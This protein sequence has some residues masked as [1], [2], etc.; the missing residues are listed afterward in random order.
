MTT[1]PPFDP[2]APLA[3]PPD[4]WESAPDAEPAVR[5][6]VPH[7]R[8][9]RRRTGAGRPDPRAPL[10]ARQRGRGARRRRSRDARGRRS[11]HRDRLRHLRAWGAGGRRDPPRGVGRGRPAER[12][13]LRRAG[14]RAVAGAAGPRPRDRRHPRGRDGRHERRP[15]GGSIGRREDGRDHGQ[16]PLACR[17]AGRRSSSRPTSSTTAGATRSAI[18]AR[19]WPP[20]RSAR[21]CPVAPID[22]AAVTRLLAGGRP[23]RGRGGG[24]RGGPR[25]CGPA[26]RHRVRRG[27]PGRPR[28]RPQGRGGIVAAVGLPRSRDLPPRAPARHGTG[29]RPRPRPDR[30]GPPRRPA[31]S[32]PAGPRG[33]SRHRSA[34]RRHPRRRPRRRARCRT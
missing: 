4:P 27:P 25:R 14:V 23:R 3:G 19:S 2:T 7:D 26:P 24:D 33:G 21:T 34:R 5:S 32:R 17:R 22:G 13:D 10:G 18:S 28:A 20:P 15:R 31:G 12:H 11:G 8:H 16:P 30:P 29:D 1:D 6:A 9:D